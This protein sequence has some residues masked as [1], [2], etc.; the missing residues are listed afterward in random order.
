MSRIW[1]GIARRVSL[2][3]DQ[4]NWKAVLKRDLKTQSMIEPPAMI[5]IKR[6]YTG[7]HQQHCGTGGTD[8]S[9]V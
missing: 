3:F 4:E 9:A 1:F 2:T 8:C 5:I 7:R 6:A